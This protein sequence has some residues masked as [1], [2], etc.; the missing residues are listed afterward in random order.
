MNNLGKVLETIADKQD[1]DAETR[2]NLTL[3]FIELKGQALEFEQY[4]G[5]VAD[6]ETNEEPEGKSG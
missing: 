3:D 1:W 6:F 4:L 2:L 5:E